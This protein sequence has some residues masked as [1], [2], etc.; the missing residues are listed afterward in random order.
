MAD[1]TRHDE[2]RRLAAYAIWRD[3]FADDMG[4]RAPEEGRKFAAAV[5]RIQEYDDMRRFIHSP[6]HGARV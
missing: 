4:P 3:A 5:A 6:S 2:E 1:T